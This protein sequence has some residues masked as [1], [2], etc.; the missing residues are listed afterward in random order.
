MQ[1]TYADRALVFAFA[2]TIASTP[3]HANLIRPA[4]L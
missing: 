4:A 3:A 2:L 1:T